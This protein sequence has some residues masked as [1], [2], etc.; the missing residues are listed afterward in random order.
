MD[1]IS[2][3]STAFQLPFGHVPALLEPGLT[4]EL[5]FLWLRGRFRF[6][7]ATLCHGAPAWFG[8]AY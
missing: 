3:R 6:R 1:E 4:I 5:E 2:R 8:A 7:P